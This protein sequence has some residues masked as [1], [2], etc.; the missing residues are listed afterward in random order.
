M[1]EI[2]VL[3]TEGL[4]VL[5]DLDNDNGANEMNALLSL[6]ISMGQ[7]RVA[8]ALRFDRISSSEDEDDDN[9]DQDN[10]NQDEGNPNQQQ[11]IHN[12][13]QDND[14]QQ[15]ESHNQ[16]QDSHNQQQ[17]DHSLNQDND[18][19]NQDN[20]NQSHAKNNSQNSC[21]EQ[22]SSDNPEPTTRRKHL[23][24]SESDRMSYSDAYVH[25]LMQN[26]DPEYLSET[27]DYELAMPGVLRRKTDKPGEPSF[28]VPSGN[29]TNTAIETN[30]GTPAT[31]ASGSDE[32]NNSLDNNQ[33]TR[34]GKHSNLDT[35]VDSNRRPR[36]KSS[37]ERP[38]VSRKSGRK[39]WT[40]I[41]SP[42]RHDR[43]STSSEKC[44][45]SPN[46]T[47]QE[48]AA[49]NVATSEVSESIIIMKML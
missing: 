21:P 12:Q 7:S 29:K 47:G 16:Q 22:S 10:H 2:N 13:Q 34:P 25:R 49:D 14:N 1:L 24:D 42:S 15:Q 39:R 20:H 27:S 6:V 8:G 35:P 18:N 41:T 33:E 37:D 38:P 30:I 28:I 19:R 5:H 36:A 32:A 45:R 3:S 9:R 23:S 26:I 48:Q 44:K 17:S 31:C 11:D 43:P 40:R 4:N 46:T